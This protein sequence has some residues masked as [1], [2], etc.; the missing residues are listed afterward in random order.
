MSNM[1]KA[2]FLFIFLTGTSL[3]FSQEG[4]Y[5]SL[6]PGEK[7]RIIERSDYRMKVNG[8]YKGHIYNEN[9]GI[10]QAVPQ[11]DGSYSVSGNYY[12][13]EELTHDGSRSTRKV[14]EINSSSYTLY[15]SGQMI[16]D[17][18]ETYPL[19]RSFPNYTAD[20]LKKGNSWL[21]WSE[22]V[23]VR[24][25][26]VTVFPVYCEYIYEGS[27]KYNGED[28]FNIRAKYAVR[29]NLGDDPDGDERLKN[30]SGTHDV[31]IIVSAV[32]GEAI[33]IRDNMKELHTYTDGGSLEKT[34]F[35]LTF[36]KGVRGLEQAQ[37]AG[38]LED[39]LKLKLGQDILDDVD[40]RESDEGLVL[41]LNKL[42][43]VPDQAVLL[44]EDVPLLDTIAVYLKSIE[45]RTFL[46]K[47]HTADVGTKE[48]QF[49]L[50]IERA[51]AIAGEL[52]KRGIP[53]DRLLYMGLGGTRPAASNDTEEGRAKNR[54]VEIVI[55]ED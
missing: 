21:S 44:K 15:S 37:L 4:I 22:K 50:S 54:R 55:M 39:D 30:I 25:D 33:L 34:G 26:S 27:G 29:Y 1:G 42:H 28:T 20:H 46:I 47:G 40:I 18:K 52:V 6:I 38:E 24:D 43:F 48:S 3:L 45:G 16:I 9:R 41:S 32:T 23:V 14:N 8:T 2:L 13:F 31:T 36:F 51:E 35:I 53:E 10:L 5:F 11:K 17:R 19:L 7:Y 12:V 49:Q